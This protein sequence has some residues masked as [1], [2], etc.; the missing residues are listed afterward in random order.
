VT[1]P[2]LILVL[3]G[4]DGRS[5]LNRGIVPGLRAGG[6][7]C[8]IRFYDWTRGFPHMLGNLRDRTLHEEQADL[9]ARQILGY[10]HS[11]P[12][13]PLWLIGHSGGAALSLLTLARLGKVTTVTGAVLLAP[14]IS[15][16]YDVQVPLTT[17]ERGIWNFRSWGDLPLAT[18]LLLGNI[19]GRRSFSAGLRGFVRPDEQP[20]GPQLHD[21]PWTPAMLRAG[22]FGGHFGCV[23]RCFIRRHVAPLLTGGAR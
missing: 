15:S 10:R 1:S 22:H 16:N 14:A 12:R 17:T 8:D 18:T 4:I 2:G 23:N 5:L 13:A 21:V 9:L 19:D 7:T 11:H 6:I 3:P 20:A